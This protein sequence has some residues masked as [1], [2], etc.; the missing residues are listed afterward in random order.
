ML[1]KVFVLYLVFNSFSL[2]IARTAK[3]IWKYFNTQPFSVTQLVNRVAKI[4]KLEITA[5]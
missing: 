5:L 4:C 1:Y 2:S 3:L